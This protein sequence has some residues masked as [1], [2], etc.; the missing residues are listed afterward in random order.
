MSDQPAV[1]AAY[2]EKGGV[3]KTTSVG[4]LAVALAEDGHDVLM[5]DLAGKQGDL[6]K[7]FGVDYDAADTDEWPNIST[8]F[9]PQWSGITAKLG[10]S[11]VDSFVRDTDEGP[12]LIPA[13]HGLDSLDS[14]LGEK[15]DGLDRFAQLDEFLREWVYDDYDVVLLDL[16]GAPNNITYSAIYAAE[17][18]LV[19]VKAGGFEDDQTDRLAE[20]VEVMREKFERNI[21][22]AMVLL[23]MVDEQTTV[24]RRY[25][26]EFAER[27]GG[28][29]APEPIPNSQ[30]VINAAQD[31]RTIFASDDRLT[32][33]DRAAEAYRVNARELYDRTH[34]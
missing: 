20:H 12:D 5:I 16:P 19:P 6:A 15:Y 23:T 18:I 21:R 30:G 2:L 28:S 8:V 13:H 1:I 14:E 9:Q 11:A 25:I 3:G 7:L 26:E 4:H 27:F 10:Q 34:E 17:D 22:I 29:L 31:G 32:T 24:S 33:A